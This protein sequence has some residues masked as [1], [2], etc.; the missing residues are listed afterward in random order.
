MTNGQLYE[1]AELLSSINSVNNSK[2]R[3]HIATCTFFD[4]E[5]QPVAT[6]QIG[7]SGELELTE[8]LRRPQLL[9]CEPYIV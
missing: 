9:T 8:L 3:L 2:S 6:A 5:G 7:A 1:A 4:G